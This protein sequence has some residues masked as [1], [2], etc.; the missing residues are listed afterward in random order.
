MSDLRIKHKLTLTEASKLFPDP[1]PYVGETVSIVL[2]SDEDKARRG[3]DKSARVAECVYLDG[4]LA[5]K[6]LVLDD[7]EE[8]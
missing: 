4:V 7:L 2:R 1:A 5:G 6:G 3:Y 8:Q